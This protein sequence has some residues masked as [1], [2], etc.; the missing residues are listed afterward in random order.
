M[1]GFSDQ[2]RLVANN[3]T[4]LRHAARGLATADRVEVT[5]IEALQRALL[6]DEKHHGLRSV[7]NWIGG[8]GWH[9]LDAEYVPPPPELVGPLTQDLVDHPNGAVHAPLIQAAL[10][11]AQFETIHPFTDGNGRVG[12]A[13]IH[14]VLTRRGLTPTALLPVSLV[15]ATLEQTYVAG[16]TAYRYTGASSDPSAQVAVARWVEV[17]LEATL[18][19]TQKAAFFRDEVEDLRRSWD[20]R[21]AAWREAQGLRSSPR[22]DSVAARLLR[23]LPEMPLLT[24]RTVERVLNVS[25]PVARNGL[26][27]LADAGVLTR[28]KVERN[29]TGYLANEVLD[30]VGSTER[31]LASTRWDTRLAAPNRPVPQRAAD[32]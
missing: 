14:S 30:V 17:F 9:P 10:V 20:R 28:R 15:L 8:S 5:D 22:S 25:P 3:M 19:A 18:V 24:A 31:Q 2:A 27:E 13:L 7:Q 4:V 11:H 12:R 23:L 6:P 32:G 21:L 26:D 1:R 29:T 16:L